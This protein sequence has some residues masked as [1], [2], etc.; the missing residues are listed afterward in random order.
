M[1]GPGEAGYIGGKPWPSSIT[2]SRRATSEEMAGAGF[3]GGP[4]TGDIGGGLAKGTRKAFKRAIARYRPGGAYG[5]GVEAALERG[6]VKAVAGG[7]QGLVSAGLA[8]TTMMGG[9]GK[10][11]EE[12]IAMPT[13]ARVE[14][15]RAGKLSELQVLK[16]QAIQGAT[17]AARSRAMQKYLAKLSASTQMQLA[18]IGR[19]GPSLTPTG[20][21]PGARPGGG[22]AFTQHT[23]SYPSPFGRDT[24]GVSADSF[25]GAPEQVGFGSIEPEQASAYTAYQMATGRLGATQVATPD[26]FA[27]VQQRLRERYRPG[28]AGAF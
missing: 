25:A 11:F 2:I 7:M 17:E 23:G 1:P 4:A 27:L 18:N 24:G 3:P 22:E 20:V 26:E 10:K 16:A 13:R 15:T 9:L 14:E 8:G 12:E 19:G 5:K 28:Q 21:S 6:R